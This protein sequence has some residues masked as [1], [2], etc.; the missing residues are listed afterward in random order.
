M[1]DVLIR[2]PQSSGFRENDW[3]VFAGFWHPIATSGEVGAKP[4]CSTLLD[5]RVVAYR[6]S[7]GVSVAL[8]RCPHRGAQLS[9]GRIKDDRLVC[10]YHGLHFDGQGHC[11]LIPAEDRADRI[12]K[13]LR[14]ASLPAVERYGLVWTSFVQEPVVPLPDWSVLESDSVVS[15]PVPPEVWAVAAPRH[16]ENFND[17]AHV[18][19]VHNDT[20]GI[21]PHNVPLYELK[22]S[23]TGLRHFYKDKGNTQ[24]FERH[25]TGTEAREAEPI[26]DVLYDYHFTY[27]LASS[28]EVKA[29]DGRSSYIFDVIQPVALKSS[30]IYKIVGRNF[31][32]DGPTDGAVAFEQAVNR[33]D[34]QIVEGMLP[35]SVPLDLSI[36]SSIKADVWSV[37]YRRGLKTFGIGGEAAS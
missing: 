13:Q 25:R 17:I 1:N 3:R 22:R 2:Y 7:S 5:T 30:R 18:S 37:A 14:L 29:P 32:L 35:D 31:D 9:H 8:D 20:F 28:L 23:K 12:P 15:A 4:Y 6:T 33:E 21:L 34:R 24:L 11:T 19:W 27:P 10:P 26:D 16:A 36:E